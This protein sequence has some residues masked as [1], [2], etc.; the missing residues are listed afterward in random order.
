MKNKVCIVTGANSGLGKETALELAELGATVVMMCRNEERG[1]EAQKEIIEA[2][3]NKE[4]EL[5]ICDLASFESTR[6]AAAEF[7]K[8]HKKLD[9]LVN[10]AGLITRKRSETEDG[11]ETQFGTNHLGTFLLT[12]LLL[13]LL[14]KSAPSRVVTVSSTAHRFGR[15]NFRDLNAEKGRYSGIRAYGQSKL[16]NVMFGYELARRLDGTGVTSNSLH[17]GGVNT[18]FG[19]GA[20]PKIF[21]VFKVFM[22]SPEK[23]ALTSV[24]LASSDEV[25]DV[26]GKYFEKCKAVRSSRP[27][28]DTEMAAKL[29]EVSEEITGISEA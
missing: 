9:V 29:W 4:V 25:D 16:A 14:K 7:K 11:H 3:G 26:S 20:M 24:Y 19:S 10:N 23:G 6:N 13:D 21:D 18:N 17:P 5:I 22:I 1:K 12:N 15:L 8:K 28:Y 27:S 2:T